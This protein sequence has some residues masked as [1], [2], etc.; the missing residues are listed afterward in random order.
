VPQTVA[1]QA[2][3]CPEVGESTPVVAAG[4]GLIL[5]RGLNSRSRRRSAR[6][7]RSSRACQHTCQHSL[8][9]RPLHSRNGWN[10]QVG[11]ALCGSSAGAA[12]ASVVRC[13]ALWPSL[14]AVTGA[15]LHSAAAPMWWPS[16]HTDAQGCESHCRLELEVS[17][18]SHGALQRRTKGGVTWTDTCK[19][20]P[21]A[22]ATLN[23]LSQS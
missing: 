6:P 5:R 19:G 22:E 9:F 4:T 21:A 23:V 7:P 20:L 16:R 18:L 11:Y 3:Q 17:S 13:A 15:H 12:Q 10:T 14:F 2:T 1:L 8:S